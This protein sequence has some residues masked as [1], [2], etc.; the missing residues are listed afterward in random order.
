VNSGEQQ[1]IAGLFGTYTICGAKFLEIKPN[2][3]TYSFPPGVSEL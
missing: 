2:F 1:V 3:V